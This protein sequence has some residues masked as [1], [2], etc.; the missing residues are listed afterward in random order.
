MTVGGK[1]LEP[2]LK[3]QKID[4]SDDLPGDPCEQSEIV[5]ELYK[6]NKQQIDNKNDSV[7]Q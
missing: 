3:R 7:T 4:K 5:A 6:T 1:T 2:R